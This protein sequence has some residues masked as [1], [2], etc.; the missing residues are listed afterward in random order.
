[1]AKHLNIIWPTSGWDKGKAYQSV[2]TENAKDIRIS[3]ML[4]S[5]RDGVSYIITRAD[6][7]MLARR[8]MQCLEETK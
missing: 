5:G 8:I 7:R 3:L 4:G 2:R 1:M 6:A